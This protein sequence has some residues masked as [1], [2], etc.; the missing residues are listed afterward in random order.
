MVD[1]MTTL[2][3]ALQFQRDM[4]KFAAGMFFSLQHTIIKLVPFVGVLLFISACGST[5]LL[6]ERQFTGN[7]GVELSN[8]SIQSLDS[9]KGIF[10]IN[11]T[12]S[13]V[14]YEGTVKAYKTRGMMLGT[15]KTWDERRPYIKRVTEDKSLYDYEQGLRHRVYQK[16][17]DEQDENI[18]YESQI[19]SD[20]KIKFTTGTDLSLLVDSDLYVEV[21]IDGPDFIQ[22]IKKTQYRQDV[23][24]VEVQLRRKV[25]VCVTCLANKGL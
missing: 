16:A 14:H 9:Q 15:F 21:S 11:L 7:A 20:G 25:S 10:L 24:S 1:D 2:N 18:R 12:V 13:E 5:T 17:H 6:E 4:T 23:E 19:I 8:L 22:S 3:I